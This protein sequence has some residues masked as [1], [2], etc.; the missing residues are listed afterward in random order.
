MKMDK[1]GKESQ[2]HVALVFFHFPS[3]LG[4]ASWSPWGAAEGLRTGLDLKSFVLNLGEEMGG[5]VTYEFIYDFTWT[6]QI[7]GNQ[8]PF[9]SY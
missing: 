6:Y 4:E 2:N 5:Q 7:L 9:T 8:N 1:M 3:R